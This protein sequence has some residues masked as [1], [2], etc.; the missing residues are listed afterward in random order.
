MYLQQHA[1]ISVFTFLEILCIV[2]LVFIS[3]LFRHSFVKARLVLFGRMKKFEMC[4]C[5]ERDCSCDSVFRDLN[6]Y[7]FVFL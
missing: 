5:H 6:I 3:A 7:R 1:L 4:G 2:F